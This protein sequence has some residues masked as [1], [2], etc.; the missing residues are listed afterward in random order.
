MAICGLRNPERVSLRA[1]LSG[2][3][4]RFSAT[5]STDVKPRRVLVQDDLHLTDEPIEKF[6]AAAGVSLRTSIPYV[7]D[8][9]ARP[10][11]GSPAANPK[12]GRRHRID[13]LCGSATHGSTRCGEAREGRDAPTGDDVPG[14]QS[15]TQ[16][17]LCVAGAAAVDAWPNA[18]CK[19]LH[20]HEVLHCHQNLKSGLRSRV[21][22]S[23]P[24]SRSR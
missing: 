3:L 1:S 11:S 18:P 17:F 8:K 22:R 10:F 14:A 20:S 7:V 9:R 6:D 21:R 13:H 12:A 5:D 19:K 16:R 24:A 23:H 4:I 2:A 15:R